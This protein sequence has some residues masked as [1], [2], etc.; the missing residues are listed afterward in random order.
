MIINTTSGTGLFGNV[1]RGPYAAGKAAV[2]ALTLSL[3][4]ELADLGVRVNAIAPA[5]RTRM[6]Q[7]TQAISD[8]MRLP[9]RA[10]DFDAWDPRH[11][12]PLVAYLATSSARTPHEQRYARR[13]SGA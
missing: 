5:A 8:M 9:E 4:Q 12:A 11:V 7:T 10:G 2:V 3:A 13:R 1:G 6:S